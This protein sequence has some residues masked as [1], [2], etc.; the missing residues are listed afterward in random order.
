MPPTPSPSPPSPANNKPRR[1]VMQFLPQI[2]AVF[3]DAYVSASTAPKL[4][5]D[6]LAET[7]ALLKQLQTSYPTELQSCVAALAPEAQQALVAA[8]SS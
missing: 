8:L 3:A 7:T 1:Q 2:V 4:K 6:T 5:A